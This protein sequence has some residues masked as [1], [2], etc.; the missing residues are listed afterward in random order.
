M[1]ELRDAGGVMINRSACRLEKILVLKSKGGRSPERPKPSWGH[2]D[3][4]N[5]SGIWRVHQDRCH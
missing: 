3:T 1:G 5:P 4:G 2:I